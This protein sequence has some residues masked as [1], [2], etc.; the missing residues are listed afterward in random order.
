MH[1]GKETSMGSG[2]RPGVRPRMARRK[3]RGRYYGF[4]MKTLTGYVVAGNFG[5]CI[6][7]V[8]AESNEEMEKIICAFME[9]FKFYSI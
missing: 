6:V 4:K 9:S 3:Y 7:G 5:Y 2:G 8:Y 1:E